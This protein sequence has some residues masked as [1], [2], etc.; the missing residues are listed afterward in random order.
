MCVRSRRSQF[1]NGMGAWC[2]RLARG[3]LWVSPRL[4]R[5]SH[6]RTRRVHQDRRHQRRGA[7]GRVVI[8]AWGRRLAEDTWAYYRLTGISRSVPHDLAV[9]AAKLLAIFPGQVAVDWGLAHQFY[10][11][12]VHACIRGVMFDRL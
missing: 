2:S 8:N 4:A 9:R 6:A 11:Q 1:L 3:D 7:G 5:S 10:L 12:G